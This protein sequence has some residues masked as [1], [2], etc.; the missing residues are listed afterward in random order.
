MISGLFALEVLAFAFVW[1][2][3][4]YMISRD[5]RNP[6]LRYAGLGLAAYALGL[7]L[8]SVSPFATTYELFAVLAPARWPFLFLPALFWIGALSYLLPEEHRWRHPFTAI[9]QYAI[10]PAA[11]IFWFLSISTNLIVGITPHGAEPGPLYLVFVVFVLIPLLALIVAIW[12]SYRPVHSERARA[13]LLVCLLLFSL[14]TGLLLFPLNLLP[15]SF[16]LPAMGVDLVILGLV[17]AVMDAFKQ[18]ETLL[19]HIVHSFD[20]SAFVAVL[21][22]GQIALMIGISGNTSLPIIALLFTVVATAIATQTFS[23]SIQIWIDKVALSRFPRLRKARADLR[24]V[25]NALPR[26]DPTPNF[27]ALDDAE[28][29]RLTRRALTHFGDL[30]RLATS[31]LIYLP[32]IGSRLRERDAPDDVLERAAELKAVLAESIARLKPRANG[33]FGTTGEW[34]HYNA[35]YFPYIVGLK[36]YSRRAT[37]DDLDQSAKEALVWFQAQVPERTLYNWQTAASRLVAQDLR[38]R[39][40]N[41]LD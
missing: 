28:F 24:A 23:E 13:I 33:H 18:G 7:A 20:T 22:G 16:L 29:A 37:D 31:P 30:P 25:E 40:A 10:L 15:R 36:P 12:Q 21:F 17:I 32:L 11:L 1:W 26:L 5:L 27:E 8:D 3:G 39:M 6:Q 41:H 34:R 38:E 35:L 4:L 2:L 9:W 14:E 19:P